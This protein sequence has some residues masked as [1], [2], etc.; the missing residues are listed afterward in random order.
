MDREYGQRGWEEEVRHRVP[1]QS[2]ARFPES[3]G[4]TLPG[5]AA[6]LRAVFNSLGNP[7]NRMLPHSSFE[8]DPKCSFSVPASQLS[9][10]IQRICCDG[11]STGLG[12]VNLVS[13]YCSV[14]EC[15]LFSPTGWW[16]H[17]LWVSASIPLNLFLF[18]F[19][20]ISSQR[21]EVLCK[22]YSEDSHLPNDT[23]HTKTISLLF[24]T[25]S[26][27]IRMLQSLAIASKTQETSWDLLRLEHGSLS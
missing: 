17:S 21:E 19:F 5:Y 11:K 6:L 8:P 4:P 15:L 22:H 9:P 13:V 26:L 24:A 16:L 7:A 2:M 1:Y 12:R 14:N 27:I 3:P 25:C 10:Q 20:F 18:F 23:G